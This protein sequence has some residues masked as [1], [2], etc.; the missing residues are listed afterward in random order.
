IKEYLPDGSFY[1]F[2]PH[3]WGDDLTNARNNV[4]V[5]RASK[6]TNTHGNETSF[7]YLPGKATPHPKLLKYQNVEVAFSYKSVP[8]IS[9]QVG[10]SSIGINTSND[11]LL[12]G[13]NVKVAD[14][15]RKSLSIGYQFTSQTDE[16]RL[17]FIQECG[18][19]SA[20]NEECLPAVKFSYSDTSN[21]TNVTRHDGYVSNSNYTDSE[22]R[23]VADLDADGIPDVMRVQGQS[24]YA[25]L[26]SDNWSESA[27]L[28]GA[29]RYA[30]SPFDYNKDGKGDLLFLK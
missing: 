28:T 4:L 11:S 19:S 17:D 6:F 9:K 20:G 10:V 26:S 14:T 18:V 30:I 25:L 21:E 2:E 5:W 22:K 3:L 24:I 16:P 27:I 1:T 29:K 12:A 8:A 7:E 13:I 23:T 15:P